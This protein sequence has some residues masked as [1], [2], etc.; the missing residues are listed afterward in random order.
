[1]THNSFANQVAIVTGAARG[2]GLGVA[3]ML[4]QA[5]VR[6]VAWDR[7]T[8]PFQQ[9]SGFQ[10]AAIDAIDV[11]D[12]DAVT[13]GIERVVHRFGRLDI[14]VNNAGIGGE[15]ALTEDYSLEGWHRVL[16]VDLTSAFLCCRAALPHMKR[17][18][19]GRILNVSS[20]AGKEG[21]AGLSAYCAAKAGVIGLTKAIAREVAEFGITANC[22][23]PV[24]VETELLAMHSPEAIAAARA[25]NPIGRLALVD[26]VAGTICFAVSPACGFTTGFVFDASGG[27]ATF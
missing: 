2:I 20:I 25:K 10:P 4:T 13:A 17:A 1:M 23:A 21:T 15:V 7:D 12:A 11:T 24:M 3:R 14:L 5:G 9:E 16:N 27:R 8:T 19:Y 26:D 18:G 6:V 22:I